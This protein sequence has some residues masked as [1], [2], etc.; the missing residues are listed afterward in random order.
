LLG[1]TW[2]GVDLEH[3]T[4]RAAQGI[5]RIGGELVLD[6]LKSA[7]SHRTLPL[8]RVAVR[9]LREHHT[10]QAAERLY[11]GRARTDLDLVFCTAIGTP[12]DPRNLNRSFR[13]LLIRAGV[14]VE[15]VKGEDGR[16]ELVTTVRLHDLR[17]S[18]ASFLLAQ[19]AS[20]RVVMETLGH[21]GIAIT[22][23][24]YPGAFMPRCHDGV[25]IN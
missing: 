17:H 20:P 8:P 22:M 24:T 23:N 7:S 9:A 14:G 15:R 10:R 2:A 16:T 4:L 3:R 19:A 21:S 13:S 12:L 11:V 5:Q 6:E 18:C 25:L 1:L